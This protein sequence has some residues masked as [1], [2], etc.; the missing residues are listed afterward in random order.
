MLAHWPKH[1]VWH[2]EQKAR[3]EQRR[4]S[5]LLD[6]DRSTAVSQ[7]HFAAITGREYDMRFAAAAAL[8]AEG[9]NHAAAE[10]AEALKVAEAKARTAAE[11]LLAEEEK[12]KQQ[13]AS[14]KGGQSKRKGKKGKGTR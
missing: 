11:E 8:N 6:S 9:D 7:A 2:K 12:E 1:K 4:E 3:A 14:T 10:A 5:T 13:A